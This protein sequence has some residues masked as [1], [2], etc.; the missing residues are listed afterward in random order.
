MVRAGCNEGTVII[1]ED[2]FAGKGQAGNSWQS[3][4]GSNLT[5][6]LVLKPTFLS[7]NQQFLITVA[8]SL[9]IKNALEDHLPGEI[10]IK[11]PND[12]YFKENKIAGIL[13]ENVLRGSNFDYCIIG[14]GLNVNQDVFPGLEQAISM[15]MI[16][17]NETNRNLLLNSLL[18]Q[19]DQFYGQLKEGHGEAMKKEYHDSLL[20]RGE[21]R[22]FRTAQA[23]FTGMIQATDENGRL[24]IWT[25]EKT[26]RFNH[27]E[28][29]ILF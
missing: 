2:Q 1:T 11:W 10:K 25:P 28:V 7:P 27:K 18:E 4:P 3:E 19:I 15:K 14:I 8:V 23:D 5:F 13:I 24:I 20:G 29:E 6:S 9:A 21:E 17:G 22:N 16:N 12:I 26:Y